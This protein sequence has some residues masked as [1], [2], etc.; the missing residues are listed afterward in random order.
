MGEFEK[1]VT[2][3][4]LRK[5]WEALR[6]VNELSYKLAGLPGP[7]TILDVGCGPGLDSVA[8]AKLAK[9]GRVTGIDISGDMLVEARKLA[10]S[11]GAA[12]NTTFVEGSADKL[13][14][15]DASFDAVRAERLFQ[16]LPKDLFPP[17]KVFA[18]MVRVLKPDG[19][20]VLVDMDWGSASIDFP[21]LDMER[22]FVGIF[23]RHTR[24][25]GYS[26]RYFKRWMI[27]A[28]LCDVE[29][30]AFARVM[31]HLEDCP[32]GAWLADDASKRG[33][34]TVEESRRWIETLT[35]KDSKGLFLATGTMM[36][37]AGR[38][39]DGRGA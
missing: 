34:A 25:N 17:E 13:P 4:Y 9:N 2:A 26:G 30:Y 33:F 23:A 7:K 28:G 36:V 19:R 32:L 35:E 12:G 14:F 37:V 31:E 38:K 22:E 24:P 20:L 27:E 16:V 39:T 8:M 1:H 3:D 18:E 5:A 10:A 21:D 11:E 6:E 15:D 29:T